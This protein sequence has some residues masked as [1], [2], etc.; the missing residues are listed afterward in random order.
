[1]PFK[2]GR[3]SME[4]SKMAPMHKELLDGSELVLKSRGL[5][6]H[7]C[8]PKDIDTETFVLQAEPTTTY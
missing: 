5:I 3:P 2:F 4:R 1:M 7:E 8:P 6:G